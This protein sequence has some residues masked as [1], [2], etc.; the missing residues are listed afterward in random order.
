MC[1]QLWERPSRSRELLDLALLVADTQGRWDVGGFPDTESGGAAGSDGDS[2]LES[3]QAEG[4]SRAGPGDG[5][6]R[7]GRG[8]GRLLG[9]VAE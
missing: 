3:C 9:L 7:E 6:G 2:D 5:G 4:L 8:H 1:H